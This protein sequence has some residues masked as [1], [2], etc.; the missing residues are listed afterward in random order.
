MSVF[1]CA[2]FADFGMFCRLAFSCIFVRVEVRLFCL[3]GVVFVGCGFFKV[4]LFVGDCLLASL[5]VRVY[6]IV[7]GD[8]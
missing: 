8:G 5:L 3:H 7:L 2:V 1:S 6:G 4:C